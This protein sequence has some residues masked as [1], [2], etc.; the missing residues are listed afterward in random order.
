MR[1]ADSRDATPRQARALL[2]GDIEHIDRG[3]LDQARGLLT[4]ATADFAQNSSVIA[5]GW[6]GGI[7]A[8]LPWLGTEVNATRAL[9]RAGEDAASAGA[10]LVGLAEQLTDPAIAQQTLLQRQ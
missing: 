10:T 5:D 8:H 9:R 1:P 3:R 6:L 2:V 4:A 7:A